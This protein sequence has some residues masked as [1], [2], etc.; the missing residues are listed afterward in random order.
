M[1]DYL[2]R[3]VKAALDRNRVRLLALLGAVPVLS[4]LAGAN[5][6]REVARYDERP[7]TTVRGALYGGLAGTIG[8]LAGYGL[9]GAAGRGINQWLGEVLKR[10]PPDFLVRN[11][12][13]IAGVIGAAHLADAGTSTG[14]AYAAY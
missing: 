13:E 11:L 5:R 8:G 14:A 9:G 7:S 2:D 1:P 12:P 4:A 3:L 10:R 6:A